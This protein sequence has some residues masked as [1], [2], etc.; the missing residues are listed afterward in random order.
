MSFTM[1]QPAPPCLT[2][3]HSPA[4][5]SCGHL[6]QCQR[7]NH[8]SSRLLRRDGLRFILPPI[9]LTTRQIAGRWVQ[10][11]CP[12]AKYQRSNRIW[13]RTWGSK[14]VSW[15]SAWEWLRFSME[16]TCLSF[17]P[18]P[19]REARSHRRAVPSHAA[20]PRY[21]HR[22]SWW[23]CET[24]AQRT[25]RSLWDQ[26][27]GGNTSS[28]VAEFHAGKRDAPQASW[29]LLHYISEERCAALVLFSKFLGS[30][31][32][33]RRNRSTKSQI[34]NWWLCLKFRETDP[35]YRIHCE[36]WHSFHLGH[37]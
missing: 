35:G 25:K 32:A 18:L 24:C 5:C 17:R 15:R 23:G 22:I 20:A 16:Q 4:I 8:W 6:P 14:K 37:W 27:R 7:W 31:G 2:Q 30:L 11:K 12:D 21:L 10:C 29:C 28:D 3:S 34:S 36:L 13:C 26:L 19:T 9:S 1:L 33:V